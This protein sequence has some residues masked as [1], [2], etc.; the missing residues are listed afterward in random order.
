MTDSGDKVDK[1]E[2]DGFRRRINSHLKAFVLL[3]STNIQDVTRNKR[4]AFS[5]IPG[6]ESLEQA[7]MFQ[8]RY[9]SV[10]ERGTSF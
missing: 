9:Y 7:C 6:G 10:G 8:L 2:G 4:S 5:Y 3:C 1:G